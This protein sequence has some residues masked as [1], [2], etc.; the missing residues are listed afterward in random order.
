MKA[1][2][3]WKLAHIMYDAY[4]L[5]EVQE[6]KTMPPRWLDAH[7][8]VKEKFL[9]LAEALLRHERSEEDPMPEGYVNAD[10]SLLI[11]LLAA[12]LRS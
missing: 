11:P 6:T 2:A 8:A 9:T 1:Q 10:E 5:L 12:G 7:D 4:C 3:V